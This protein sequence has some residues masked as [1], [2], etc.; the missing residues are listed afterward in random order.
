MYQ[1]DNVNNLAID[2]D[3]N[4]TFLIIVT[5]PSHWTVGFLFFVDTDVS[6]VIKLYAGK[7][8]LY[9]YIGTFRIN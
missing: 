7:N 1:T 5:F 8:D 6:Y 3:G 9:L 4:I 2:F